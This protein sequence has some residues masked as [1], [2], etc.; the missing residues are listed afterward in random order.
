MKTSHVPNVAAVA[1][2]L[3]KELGRARSLKPSGTA[4]TTLSWEAG[5]MAGLERALALLEPPPMRAFKATVKAQDASCLG[6]FDWELYVEATSLAMAQGI[7][8]ARIRKAFPG[9]GYSYHASISTKP[10]QP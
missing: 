5:F 9:L 6:G 4:T 3:K 8:L 7:A 2:Q 10:V 1:A